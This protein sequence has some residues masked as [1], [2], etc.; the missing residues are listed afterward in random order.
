MSMSI[1]PSG[2]SPQTAAAQAAPSVP[3][4]VA[5]VAAAAPAAAGAESVKAPSA[6]EQ[7]QE[8]QE[9]VQRLNEQMRTQGRNLSFSMD[10]KIDRTIIQVK[11]A[12]TGEVVRQIPDETVLKVSRSI[13]DLKGLLL[14]EKT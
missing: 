3:K 13:E 1:P 12:N 11:D 14:N 2:S 6:D 8:L 9:A 4:R 7:R 5:Q 10:E